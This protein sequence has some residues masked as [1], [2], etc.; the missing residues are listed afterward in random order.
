MSEF[1]GLWKHEKTQHALC[2]Q[3]GLGSATVA[4]GYPLGKLP[5]FPMGE[6]PIPLGQQSVQNTQY[7]TNTIRSVYG[8]ALR[9]PTNT[10][11]LYIYVFKRWSNK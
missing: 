4:A 2:N 6:I 9:N 10:T 1:S 3:I 5:E 11:L 7:S 8:G